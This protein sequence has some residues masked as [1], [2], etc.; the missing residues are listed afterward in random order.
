MTLRLRTG[1]AAACAAVLLAACAPREA[2]TTAAAQPDAAAVEQ[3]IRALEQRQVE[4]ALSGD[5]ETLLSVF[6]PEFHMVNPAGGIADREELVN[7]LT[8]ADRPYR[9]ATYTTDW[10]RVHG[11]I[12]TSTGTEEVEFGGDRAGQK[13]VRRITQVWER[14]DGRWQLALRH[15]TLV[16]PAP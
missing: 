7:L 15:A 10:L 3:E 14:R 11:D 8:G 1:L 13:Q 5:R 16:T 4:I 6:S 12:V 9:A 2:A